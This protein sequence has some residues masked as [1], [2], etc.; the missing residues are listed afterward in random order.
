MHQLFQFRENTFHL[1]KLTKLVT[2][3]KKTSTKV[4]HSFFGL[5]CHLNIKTRHQ[6]NKPKQSENMPSFGFQAI[7]II[8]GR[9]LD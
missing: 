5:D 1:K 9:M 4:E 8:W 3:N 6:K 7:Y 2:H